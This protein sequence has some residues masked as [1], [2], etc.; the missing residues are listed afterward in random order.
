MEE[1]QRV[2]QVEVA[3]QRCKCVI[4][5]IDKLPCSTNITHSCKRTLLKLARAELAFLSRPSSSS[6]PLSVN[7]GHLETVVHI[8]QQP[9][10]TGVSRVCKSIPLSPSVSSEER[11]GSSL[12]HIHVDVVCT[13]N[14]KPVWIIVSDRNP[15]YISWER[16]RKSKGLKLRIQEVLAAAQSNLTLRPS[17]V[18]L[19]FANGL[20][21]NIY[22]KLRDELGAY[23]IQLDFSVFS[24]DVLEET[25][26]DWIN[27]IARSYRNS[28]VLEINPAVG[29]DVVPNS[30]C[31]IQGSAVDSSQIDL[32]VGKA[33]T[34]PQ[35]LEENARTGDYSH[36]E[37]FVDEAKTQPQPIGENVGI[38]LGDT[39]CSIL[40]GMKPSSMEIKN[41]ESAKP[42]NLLGETDLVNFDTTALIA[43]VSGI[44]NGGTDKLLATPESE[45]RQRFKG[46]FDFVIGQIMSEI[47]NP[48]HLK[49]GRIL[50]GKHGLI[51]ESVLVEFKELVLMCGGPNEKLRAARLID[52]L[53]V[54]PDTPSERMMGLPTTR[55]LALKNK[56][57]FGTG[58][59]WHAP[60]L[61]ANMAFVRAVSQTGMS[62]STIEHRPRALT[63]D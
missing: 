14:R 62:L 8:L 16:S 32:S 30:G 59:H 52:Y 10:I 42:G 27:V 28:C 26:G 49:F 19:F 6:G 47:Q 60:T 2:A 21:T 23:E 57:V 9:F 61:T 4:D 50:H 7:I 46:N 12:K 56:V 40:M 35:Q 13:L 36:L 51:C 25:E 33:E 31:I 38:N 44:S 48:I 3:K 58:D 1:E 53:R 39:F 18:I 15:E 22:N 37:L 41:F 11:R 17:S 5:A 34:Q 45:M 54:V 55:K 20:A 63:G 43:L 29:K 24:S